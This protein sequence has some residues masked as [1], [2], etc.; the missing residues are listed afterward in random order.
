MYFSLEGHNPQ[1]FTS[2]TS[3]WYED[4]GSVK[5]FTMLVIIFSIEYEGNFQ[6]LVVMKQLEKHHERACENIIVVKF[7]LSKQVIYQHCDQIAEL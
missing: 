4:P 2:P 3:P 5:R 7:N 1:P 6:C